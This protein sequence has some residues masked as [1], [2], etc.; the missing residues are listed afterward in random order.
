VTL[1]TDGKS[2]NTG[3]S[4]AH[5]DNRIAYSSTRRTGQDT[6]IWIMDPMNPKS[7]K[8]LLQLEGGGW[9]VVDW[10]PDNKKLLVL[11]EVSANQ[12]YLWLADVATGEKKLLTP[13]AEA[14]SAKTAKVFTPP[15]TVNRSSIGW[16]ILTWQP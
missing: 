15:R 11:Q 9:G 4:F 10:S 8:M 13:K 5:N 12:S 1:L 7:D 16:P 2:R 3:R 6:D 14:R